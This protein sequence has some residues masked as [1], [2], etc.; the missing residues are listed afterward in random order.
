M[1]DV[2]MLCVDVPPRAAPH[3]HRNHPGGKRRA[4]VV[5]QSVAHVGD[6]SRR[7]P[8]LGDDP[9]EECC[10]RLLDSPA[11][12]G[13]DEVSWQVQ[14]AKQALG[15]CGLIAC[16]SDQEAELPQLPQAGMGVRVQVM[17]VDVLGEVSLLAAE[18][19]GRQV[20]PG[21]EVR[22]SRRSG[23]RRRRI[24]QRERA[25]LGVARASEHP[26]GYMSV[27]RSSS[28]LTDARSCHGCTRSRNSCSRSLLVA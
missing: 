23:S 15:L 3:E 25:G 28:S 17:L 13:A 22:W 27:R 19:L 11:G 21:P 16:D 1:A 18:P 12:R 14:G 10:G 5:A 4:D 20:E 2:G 9:V 6:L 24:P 7:A 8:A 26:L